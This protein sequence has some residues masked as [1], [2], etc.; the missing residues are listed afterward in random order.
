MMLD[1]C[2]D[3]RG[4][5]FDRGELT[6]LD[7][8][9]WANMERHPYHDV[10]GDHPAAVCPKCTKAMYDGREMDFPL[11]PLSP[12]DAQDLIVDR[13]PSCF[14]FW[15]DRGE[16]KRIVEIADA[17]DNMKRAERELDR[18]LVGEDHGAMSI[19]WA[20]PKLSAAIRA[21]LV[22][23]ARSHPTRKLRKNSLGLDDYDQQPRELRVVIDKWY[24]M[25]NAKR[26][27]LLVLMPEEMQPKPSDKFE[28]PRSKRERLT[29]RP[30]EWS[31]LKWVTYQFRHHLASDTDDIF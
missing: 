6:R 12:L 28:P 1:I 7:G 22:L 10:E 31:W 27:E 29:K 2:P 3:C 30:A 5:W 15:L 9:V 20:W 4:A 21:K 18:N 8:S 23:M 19:V 25:S 14:G 24:V 11:E 17:C 13:C 16:L 26:A